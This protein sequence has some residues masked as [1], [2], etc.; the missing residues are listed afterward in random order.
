MIVP[1]R[2][3]GNKGDD[4][5]RRHWLGK[6]G[7]RQETLREEDRRNILNECTMPMSRKQSTTQ[8]HRGDS[9]SESEKF[10][11]I[12]RLLKLNLHQSTLLQYKTAFFVKSVELKR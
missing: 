10:R 11:Q 4:S 12:T 3:L 2:K 8:F 6:Y 1:G 5:P 9:K 7:R